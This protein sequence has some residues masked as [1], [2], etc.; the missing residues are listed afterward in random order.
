MSMK[1]NSWR[2]HHEFT[3]WHEIA[4]IVH[5][6]LFTDLFPFF[7]FFFEN[8]VLKFYVVFL[9]TVSFSPWTFQ[10][11]TGCCGGDFSSRHFLKKQSFF[12]SLLQE[13]STLYWSKWRC[14]PSEASQHF[15]FSMITFLKILIWNRWGFSFQTTPSYHMFL[16]WC[17][18]SLF[19]KITIERDF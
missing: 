8:S 13:V 10:Y 18:L 5:V 15:R 2:K 6:V 7:F 9:L 17:L 16:Q 12:N 11:L 4:F 3:C 19:L 1:I 14:R